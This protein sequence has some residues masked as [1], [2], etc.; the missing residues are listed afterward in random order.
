MNV[1]GAIPI[2]DDPGLCS[3]QELPDDKYSGRLAFA[4]IGDYLRLTTGATWPNDE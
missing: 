4:N 3:S 2:V 1:D